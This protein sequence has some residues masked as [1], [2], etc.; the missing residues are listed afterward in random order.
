MKKKIFDFL[1]A[2]IV[3]SCVFFTAVSLILYAGAAAFAR[4]SEA[5]GQR[6]A[7]LVLIFSVICGFMTAFLTTGVLNVPVRAVLHYAV[8]LASFMLLFPNLTG[9]S[10]GGKGKGAVFAVLIYT[11]LWLIPFIIWLAVR[12]HGRKKE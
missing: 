4:N 11:V 9:D 8:T 1:K 6:T 5:M 12:S 2:A 10:G 3:R 7:F